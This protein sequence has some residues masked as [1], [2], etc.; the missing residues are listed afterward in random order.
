[1]YFSLHS[2]SR[3]LWDKIDA[4]TVIWHFLL[5]LEVVSVIT[6]LLHDTEPCVELP[7]QAGEKLLC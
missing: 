7:I 3:L 5:D 6:P 2:L 4:G 1:M